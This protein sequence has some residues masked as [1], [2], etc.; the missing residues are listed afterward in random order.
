MAERQEFH[1]W[2]EGEGIAQAGPE[3]N[4]SVT[5]INHTHTRPEPVAPDT[6][7]EAER[8]LEG[9]PLDRVPDPGGIPA[10]SKPPPNPPNPLLVGRQDDLELLAEKIKDNAAGPPTVVVSGI[11]GVG[12]TQLAAEFAHRYGRYF[13]GGVYWLKLSDPAAINEEVA[14]CG[15]AGA[16]NLRPD[17]RD[18]SLE[19]RFSEVM[20]EWY[21]DLPR[22]LVLDDCPDGPTLSAI[23]PS[24]GGCRVLATSRGPM[25]NPTLGVVA[26][27]LEPLER[28]ASVELLRR[29]HDGAED[30]KLDEIA[31]ELGDLPLALDLAGRYLYKY[32]HIT[33]PER[34]LKA[35][36][37]ED[38]LSHRSL[39]EIDECE[40]SPTDHDM[41]VRRTFAISIHHL[42]EGD[43]VDRLAVKL[44]ARAARFAPGELINRRLLLSTLDVSDEELTDRQLEER[45]DALRR[46][47]ELGLVSESDSGSVSMHKLVAASA[48]LEIEDD[49]AQTSVERAV[50]ME[51]IEV[52]TSGQ[53][54]KLEPLM[55]H[56]RHATEVAGDRDDEPAYLVRFA[57]G[58]SLLASGS[59]AEAV[60]YLTSA[61]EYN[62]A[63]LEA[64]DNPTERERLIWLIMRQRND[65]GVALERAGDSDGALAIH[66]PLLED[67]RNNLPQPHEDI[68]STLINIGALKAKLGLLH[69]VAPMYEEAI[70][71]REAV[72][73]RMSADHP[74][75]KQLL[76]DLAESHGNLGALSMDL[77]RPREAALS[78]QRALKIY[79]DLRETEHERY[80]NTSMALGAA[81]GLLGNFDDARFHLE[82]ALCLYRRILPEEDTRIVKNLILLGALLTGEVNR[83]GGSTG[84]QGREILDAARGHLEEALDN[85][86]QRWGDDHPL[87]AGVMSV[88]ADVAAAEGRLED[89]ASL[90]AKAD[91]IRTT[92]LHG[93]N[94]EFIGEGTEIFASRGL[95]GEA[96]L[97]GKRTLDL[98]RSAAEGGSL[99]VAEAKLAL[100]CLFLLLGRDAEAAPHLQEAFNLREAILGTD[101]PATEL[102][103]DCLSYL[104]E[105]GN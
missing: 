33:G 54:V 6:L 64:T 93:A 1:Q 79:E 58:H 17:F 28:V 32:R 94:A 46:L 55:P 13:A 8:Q 10:G 53:P 77:G 57:T 7:A 5:I 75:R 42:D 48:R 99:E 92:V 30:V 84:E 18:L 87:T 98:R 80:A 83:D 45:E 56:L 67:R 68:A 37:A 15:G 24:T 14:S 50:A 85:L 60:S 9:L 63:R 71:I 25:T 35:L 88:A 52:V 62:A 49:E 47:V 70:G 31:S 69:E 103:R 81:L 73:K 100:G 74:E 34:Y 105:H 82:R 11:G 16:M 91:V 29:Y 59:T 95:Y 61:V 4:A 36:R 41:N 101:D 39:D 3:G 12:K 21:S 20:S 66:E 97:Y 86:S 96:E 27:A 102:V 51:A 43:T 90:R 26:F 22:L 104:R 2:A 76:R 78:Y 40:V 44:L 72:L 89:E 38:V 65:V 19:D 23:R